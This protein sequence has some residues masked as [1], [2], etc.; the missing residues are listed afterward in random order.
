MGRNVFLILDQEKLS[1]AC[2]VERL[3]KKACGGRTEPWFAFSK[4]EIPV[5][6]LLGKMSG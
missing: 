3:G 6:E 1:L 4:L 2:I 5:N